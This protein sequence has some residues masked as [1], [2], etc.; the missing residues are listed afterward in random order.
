MPSYTDGPMP[1]KSR[2]HVINDLLNDGWTIKSDGPTG[3]VLHNSTKKVKTPDKVAL[4]AGI[5]LTPL[6]PPI[7]LFLISIALFD[8]FLLTKAEIKFVPRED[9]R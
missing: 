5:F 3:T 7:G 1:P 8:Y 6:F 9:I 4:V 2:N